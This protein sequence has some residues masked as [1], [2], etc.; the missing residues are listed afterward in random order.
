MQFNLGMA[1]E[2]AE[3]RGEKKQSE[4][5]FLFLTNSYI[6]WIFHL[7]SNKER[8][9]LLKI[10]ASLSL[11]RFYHAYDNYMAHAF[12]VGSCA[13]FSVIG[14]CRIFSGRTCI[15]LF[16][17]LQHDELK[18]LSKTFTDSLSE[19]GNLNVNSFL[20]ENIKNDHLQIADVTIYRL[21][22]A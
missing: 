2:L 9:L 22:S 19:L 7:F 1:Y 3:A 17:F 21:I 13:H 20:F 8:I 11:F 6:V 15:I 5:V 12:P 14:S 4:Q 16:C 10:D 18:P